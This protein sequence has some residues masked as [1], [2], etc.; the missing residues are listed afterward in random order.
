VS[1]ITTEGV[2]AF[3]TVDSQTPFT[4]LYPTGRKVWVETALRH[5]YVEEDEL[6]EE[7]GYA[8]A[9]VSASWN[10]TRGSWV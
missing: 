7:K 4:F 6:R 5:N 9:N 8:Q 10:S 2:T 3:V 1:S